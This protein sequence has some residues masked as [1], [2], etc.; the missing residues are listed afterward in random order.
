MSF[1]AETQFVFPPQ[2]SHNNKE[3]IFD[4]I[5]FFECMIFKPEFNHLHKFANKQWSG[6]ELQVFTDTVTLLYTEFIL[7]RL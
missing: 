2:P 6:H 5:Q 7:V 3:Y 1:T 4:T